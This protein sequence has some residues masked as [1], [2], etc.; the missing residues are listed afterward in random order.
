ML[1]KTYN[2]RES[3]P[4]LISKTL[5]GAN[6]RV[7]SGAALVTALLIVA[8][9]TVTVTAMTAKQQ[10]AIQLAQNRQTQLQLKN[11]ASAGEKFA[12][13]T[14]RRDHVL[15]E[16][17]NSDSTEDFWAESLPPLPVDGA[18]VQG[19]VIDLQGKFNLN[20]LVDIEGNVDN[21]EYEIL[22]RLLTALTIDETKADAIR[23]WIDPNIEVTGSNGAEDDFY[24]GQTPGYRAANGPMVSPSE[25]LLVKGFRVVDEGGLDD[26]DTLLPHIATLPTGAAI[27]V[28]TASS[29][30]LAS[31]APHMA[32]IADEIKVVDDEYWLE[33]PDCPQGGGLLD[34]LLDADDDSDDPNQAADAGQPENPEDESAGSLVYEDIEAFRNDAVGTEEDEN[35][36][37]VINISVSSRY[38]MSRVT[39][40]RDDINLTQYTI[41]EREPGG[42]T[43]RTLRRS[44]GSL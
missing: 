19:C 12:M 25:L 34:T 42:G 6:S 15:A 1:T 40:S 30:V 33:F 36:D 10:R 41:F 37:N 2:M 7:Q 31:L 35:L 14:L 32:A 13:A 21:E 5:P 44:R 27:N 8:L 43:L 16:R 38:Y 26:F 39:V 28:N 29:A 23:D 4:S 3:R 20:N 22:Q 24:T 17:N 11:L 9:I 18:T